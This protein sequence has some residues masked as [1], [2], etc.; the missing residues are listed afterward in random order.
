MDC[1]NRLPCPLLLVGFVREATG[2]RLEESVAK[3]CI[4]PVPP[5]QVP[6]VG[7]VPL[8]RATV[9]VTAPST[10]SLPPSCVTA[11]PTRPFRLEV[12]ITPRVAD[13][14][15]RHRHG[16]IPYIQHLPL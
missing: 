4:P 16:C 5:F 12:V 2:K 13:P 1:T 10:Q 3:V 15:K 6:E 11:P 7:Y 9:S 8:L 14:R